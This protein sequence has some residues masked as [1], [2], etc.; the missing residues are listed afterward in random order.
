M[1]KEYYEVKASV[2][3]RNG[4][5]RYSIEKHGVAYLLWHYMLSGVRC[6]GSIQELKELGITLDELESEAEE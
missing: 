1:L 5:L 3:T 4:L 2:G 6:K